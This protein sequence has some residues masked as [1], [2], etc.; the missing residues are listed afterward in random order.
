MK[1]NKGFK[2]SLMA[3]L[4]AVMSG[5][6]LLTCC[7]FPLL[8]SILA[9][10]GIGSSQ[11]AFFAEYQGVFIALSFVSILYGFKLVYF[12]KKKESCCE[13]QKT[14]SCCGPKNNTSF[15]TKII[16]WGALIG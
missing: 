16:L 7:G 15:F 6:G 14:E 3:V 1:M 2:V 4:T 8:V 9:M 11:L 12:P 10:V 13:P 5:F